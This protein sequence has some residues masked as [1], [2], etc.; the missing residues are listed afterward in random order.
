MKEELVSCLFQSASF[1]FLSSADFHRREK[2]Q[3][4]GVLRLE[5]ELVEKRRNEGIKIEFV[6]LIALIKVPLIYNCLSSFP[7][8]PCTGQ[9]VV[10]IYCREAKEGRRRAPP[11]SDL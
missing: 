10:V 7:P 9:L 4:C 1:P 6:Q 5:L 8:L 11:V 3:I 2:N